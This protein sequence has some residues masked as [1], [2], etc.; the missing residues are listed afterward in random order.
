MP[1]STRR[2]S[3]PRT[4]VHGVVASAVSLAAAQAIRAG[5]LLRS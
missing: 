1:G 4:V 5:L 3:P 2:V